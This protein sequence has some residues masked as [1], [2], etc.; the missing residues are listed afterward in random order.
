MIQI[1]TKHV[2]DTQP[3]QDP[4]LA[5][6]RSLTCRSPSP[7]L[8]TALLG[9][10]AACPTLLSLAIPWPSVWS[11]PGPLSLRAGPHLAPERLILSPYA[12]SIRADSLA[13]SRCLAWN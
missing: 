13:H 8:G 11:L 6:L 9:R 4:T 7:A 2:T 12:L 1:H 3:L 5:L 10:A